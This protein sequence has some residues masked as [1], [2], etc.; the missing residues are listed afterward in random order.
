M[1]VGQITHAGGKIL[2]PSLFGELHMPPPLMRIE[3][4][5]QI[6]RAVALVFIVIAL[7][8]T[9]P[10]W[11]W[12]AHLADQ[13][14]RRFVK[15]HHR[16]LRIG[17]FG[18]QIQHLLHPRDVAAV[19]LRN[20]PHLPSPRFQIV[21]VKASAHRLTRETVV[22]GQP[23]HLAGQQFQR[24]A[25]ASC[26]WGRTRGGYQQRRLLAGQ[27]AR[28]PRA[29]LLAQRRLEVAFN[30]ASPGAIDRRE[31]NRDVAGN[32]LVAG[33]GVGCQQDLRPLDL[34]HRL[35]ATVQQPGKLAML[36]LVQIDPITYIHRCSYTVEDND[37]PGRRCPTTDFHSQA[38]AISRVYSHLHPGEWTS[39]SGGGHDAILPP[40]AAERPSDDPEAGESRADFSSAR[41]PAEHRRAARALRLTYARTTRC[42]TGQNLCAEVLDPGSAPKPEL[43]SEPVLALSPQ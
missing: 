24:P 13:L 42:S 6:G 27:L 17:R 39:S 8:L 43:G 40:H 21:L 9:R 16:P 19:N 30:K 41:R 29:G 3:K 23:D 33:T 7:R 12:L 4:Y 20:A 1:N 11:N 2:R 37:E 10:G 34:A 31:A 35:G 5:K 14:G 38:G 26:G 15:A 25:L 32:H 28:R 22:L 36:R 18:I